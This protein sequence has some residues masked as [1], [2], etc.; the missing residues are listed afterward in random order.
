MCAE[1]QV[2]VMVIQRFGD[3]H[4]KV[5]LK[6][7]GYYVLDRDMAHGKPPVINKKTVGLHRQKQGVH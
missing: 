1:D 7:S 6:H 2:A 5:S 3:F 4:Y